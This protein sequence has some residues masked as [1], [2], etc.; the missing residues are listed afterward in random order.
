MEPVYNPLRIHSATDH[1]YDHHNWKHEESPQTCQAYFIAV[2][3]ADEIYHVEKSN[4][5]ERSNRK[6]E[7]YNPTYEA[8]RSKR[9][10]RA[11]RGPCFVVSSFSNV[12]AT[13]L[14][15]VFERALS[16]EFDINPVAC[17]KQFYKCINRIIWLDE[18]ICSG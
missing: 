18:W 9:S 15:F 13:F 14:N 10:G 4:A 1:R 3:V 17:P 7:Q 11:G 6:T 2:N 5:D 8:I 12:F 16:G